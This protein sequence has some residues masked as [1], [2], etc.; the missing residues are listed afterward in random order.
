MR[1]VV[2]DRY[3]SSDTWQPT[4]IGRPEIND[5]EVLLQVHA[6]GLDRGTWHEMTGRPYL[7]RILGFGLRAPKNP[8]P[9]A[10]SPGRSSPSERG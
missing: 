4:D 8:C 9:D 7:M 10:P 3:G 2:Q 6:A 5:H 1:A